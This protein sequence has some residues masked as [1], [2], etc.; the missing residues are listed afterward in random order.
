M[1]KEILKKIQKQE[2]KLEEIYISVEK[3]RKYLLFTL[4]STLIIFIIPLIM[5]IF[6]VPR[7]IGFY[8]NILNF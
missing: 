7:I 8:S 3:T 2:E 1:E 4:I 5:I 6:I